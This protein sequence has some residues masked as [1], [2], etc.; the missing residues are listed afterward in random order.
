MDEQIEIT[1]AELAELTE[2]ADS[3]KIPLDSQCAYCEK[4]TMYGDPTCGDHR[5]CSHCGCTLTPSDQKLCIDNK[6]TVPECPACGLE[7]A[8]RMRMLTDKSKVEIPRVYF[9]YLNRMRLAIEPDEDLSI[10]T[11]QKIAGLKM[12]PIVNTLNHEQRLFMLRRMQAACGVISE[13]LGRDR[14][15]IEAD[16]KE[17]ESERFSEAIKERAK[18]ITPKKPKPDEMTS[19]ELKLSKEQKN[20]LK[21]ISGMIAF[22]MKPLEAIMKM[23]ESRGMT[24]D[25][26]R[27][28]LKALGLGE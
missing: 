15:K 6:S 27:E 22:G 21:A 26:A 17:R 23:G 10:E 2:L 18:K 3:P 16:I 19:E 1:D 12:W 9:E 7:F 28:E 14:K 13:S 25:K 5:Y 11:N 20:L 4:K 24:E 8:Y